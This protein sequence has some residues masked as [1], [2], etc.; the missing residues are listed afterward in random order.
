[1]GIHQSCK[2]ALLLKV[3]TTKDPLGKRLQKPS[4]ALVASGI[5]QMVQ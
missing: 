2:T 4:S 3:K 1:M 5:E